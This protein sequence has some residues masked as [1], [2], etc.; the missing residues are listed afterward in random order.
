M[1]QE[2]GDYKLIGLMHVFLWVRLSS[3]GCSEQIS[4]I[5]CKMLMSCKDFSLHFKCIIL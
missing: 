4:D 5:L 3:G 2:N 1:K